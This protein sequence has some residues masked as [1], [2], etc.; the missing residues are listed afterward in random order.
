MEKFE[1]RGVIYYPGI[2]FPDEHHVAVASVKE[3]LRIAKED[4]KSFGCSFYKC[5]YMTNEAGQR[6]Y[7]DSKRYDHRYL[8]G[9]KYSQK[10]VKKLYVDDEAFSTLITNMEIN[11]MKYVVK[12]RRGSW[13]QYYSDD[14]VLD[15]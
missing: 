6:F 12:T 4:K 9:K 10:E 1:L 14:I 2:F 8:F 5:S 3:G 7:G 15:E 13:V 11:R